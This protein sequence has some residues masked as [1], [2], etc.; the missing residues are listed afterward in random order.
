M[1]RNGIATNASGDDTAAVV[2]GSV[3]PEPVVEPP[4]DDPPPAERGEQRDAADDRRQ[5][6]RHGDQRAASRR[7][8]TRPGERQASGT[9]APGRHR[10]RGWRRPATG[11]AP[12]A[13]PAGEL[14][15]DGPPRRAHHETDHGQHEEEHRRARRTAPAP[16]LRPADALTDE[17]SRQL[18]ARRREHRPPPV[19]EHEVHE[20]LGA[21]GVGRLASVDDP[22]VVDASPPP[23]TRCPR[24]RRPPRSR[25]CGRRAPRPPRR[26]RPWPATP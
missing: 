26:A 16:A 21:L 19:G 15:A 7:P 3:M 11:A 20:R 23:G 17:S 12:R 18:E 9:P 4:A 5:H 1:T 2:N 14:G 10:W 13:T 6:Q 25:R 8:G 24:R 22:V